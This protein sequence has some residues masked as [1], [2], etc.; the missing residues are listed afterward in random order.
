MTTLVLFLPAILLGIFLRKLW[1][2]A[3]SVLVLAVNAL[4]LFN[5]GVQNAG[6]GTFATWAALGFVALTTSYLIAMW[7]A[8]FLAWLVRKVL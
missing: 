7:T 4:V 5:P 2:A 1:L 3:I 6:P 8:A